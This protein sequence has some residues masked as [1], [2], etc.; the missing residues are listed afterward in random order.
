MKRAVQSVNC[1]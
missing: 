1:T